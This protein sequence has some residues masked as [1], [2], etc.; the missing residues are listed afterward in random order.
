MSKVGNQY[1]E[2]ELIAGGRDLYLS[3]ENKYRYIES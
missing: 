3:E 2:E 1:I